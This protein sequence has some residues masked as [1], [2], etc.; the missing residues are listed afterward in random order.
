MVV[1]V[2]MN[3]EHDDHDGHDHDHVHDV[4]DGH[5]DDHGH[6][7]ELCLLYNEHYLLDDALLMLLPSYK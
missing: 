2:H 1:H 6:D 3:H 4:H 7:H 5:D